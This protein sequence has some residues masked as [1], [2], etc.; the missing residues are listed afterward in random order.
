MSIFYWV[1]SREDLHHIGLNDLENVSN[2]LGSKPF[3]MG[4]APRC[5]FHE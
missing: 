3:L 2:W 4:N 5:P 1:G